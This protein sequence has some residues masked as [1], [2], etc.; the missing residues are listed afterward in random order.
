MRTAEILRPGVSSDDSIPEQF[1]PERPVAERPH[2]AGWMKP[3]EARKSVASFHPNNRWGVVLAGGD[4]VRLRG[5]TRLVCG[6]DRPKQFCPLLGP[7]TLLDEARKR[8]ERSI[9]PKQILFPVTRAHERYYQRY[10]AGRSAQTIVA[11]SNKGTAPAILY[12]LLRI[13]HMDP[14][15]IVAVLPSDHY[16]SSERAFTD[17]LESAFDIAEV[18]ADSIILVGAQPSG[19]ETEYGW[20]EVGETLVE[21]G[22][23]H[24]VEGLRE[25][26]PIALAQDL[27]CRSALW[28]TFV[29]IGHVSAFLEMARQT[30]PD[31]LQEL[32]SMKVMSPPGAEIRIP[33]SVY[34]RIAPAD[35]AR[36]VLAPGADHLLALRLENTEWSDLGDPLRVLATL[37]EKTGDLPGWARFWPGSGM[38]RRSATAA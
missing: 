7:S 16:Y 33:D 3:L 4:G 15:A 36:Q 35:F 27:F 20:I 23:V 5:L 26:P 17:T 2:S 22:G 8:A 11:P 38:I 6:D 19:P 28:S 29:M 25:K 12:P 32:E 9:H 30:V 1:V 34:D 14:N 37:A 18:Q 10:L 21:P 31:L 24:R 13:A